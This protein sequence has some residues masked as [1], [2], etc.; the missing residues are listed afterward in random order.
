MLCTHTILK[1]VMHAYGSEL[2]TIFENIFRKKYSLHKIIR[3]GTFLS[4][5]NKKRIKNQNIFKS[6]ILPPALFLLWL[7]GTYDHL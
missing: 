4:V 6:S 3:V 1:K 2:D 5:L 7:V